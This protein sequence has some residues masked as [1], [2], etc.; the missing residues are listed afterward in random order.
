VPSFILSVIID[1]LL[2]NALV[3]GSGDIAISNDSDSLL[4]QN[5][6]RTPRRRPNRTANNREAGGGDRGANVV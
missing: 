1:N 4:I 6:R 5:H 2:R 3:H